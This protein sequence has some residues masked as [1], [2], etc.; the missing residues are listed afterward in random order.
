M[1]TVL[2]IFAMVGSMLLRMIVVWIGS[3]DLLAGNTVFDIDGFFNV[4]VGVL[5]LVSPYFFVVFL[6]WR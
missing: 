6:S 3:Y 1:V 5:V 2:V 4:V